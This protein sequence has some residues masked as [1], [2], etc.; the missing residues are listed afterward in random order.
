MD[1][2]LLGLVHD[3][4]A[5]R[6]NAY[7]IGISGCVGQIAHHVLLDFLGCIKTEHRQIADIELDDF[8]PLLFHLT[9]TVHD[10]TTYVV[11]HVGQLGGFQNGFQ[12]PSLG[13]MCVWAMQVDEADNWNTIACRR[14]RPTQPAPT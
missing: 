10:R 8:L 3:R 2:L 14:H 9:G 1:M 7:A 4:F 6:K 5:G 11:T 13:G 12:S